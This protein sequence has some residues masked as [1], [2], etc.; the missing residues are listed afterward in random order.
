MQ[1]NQYFGRM[2]K[3]ISSEGGDIF[4]FA[5]DALIVLWPESDDLQAVC[6]RAAQCALQFQTELH[7]AKVNTLTLLPRMWEHC[8]CKMESYRS[9]CF[10]SIPLFLSSVFFLRSEVRE[11]VNV[12]SRI[13]TETTCHIDTL[14]G[15]KCVPKCQSRHRGWHGQHLAHGRRFE[16]C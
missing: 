10:F 1:L 12:H 8:V 14:V 15:R 9:L 11:R 7:E 6:R 2:V 3:I 4:K 16:S 5:G 13:S